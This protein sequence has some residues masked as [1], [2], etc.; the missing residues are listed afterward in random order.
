MDLQ[1][2]TFPFSS[3][4]HAGITDTNIG[5]ELRLLT[6]IDET[7]L[8]GK[9]G[10]NIYTDSSLQQLLKENDLKPNDQL[11]IDQGGNVLGSIIKQE[12]QQVAE[13]IETKP[14]KSESRKKVTTSEGSTGSSKDTAHM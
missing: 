7:K 2:Y 6:I 5:D 10:I 3:V 14:E 11:I 4:F 13:P 8:Q 1:T 9:A 12:P